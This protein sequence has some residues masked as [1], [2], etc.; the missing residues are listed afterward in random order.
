MVNINSF[1]PLVERTALILRLEYI[2][3][4]FYDHR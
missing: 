2:D 4:T 3:T 1:Y